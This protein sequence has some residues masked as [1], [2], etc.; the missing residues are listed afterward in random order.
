MSASSNDSHFY[1][2]SHFLDVFHPS[3]W[4]DEFPPLPPL[5][6]N[7][8]QVLAFAPRFGIYAMR[9]EVKVHKL[10]LVNIFDTGSPVNAISSRL[11]KKIKMV[12]N[13]NHAVF[14]GTAGMAS[15]KSIMTYSASLVV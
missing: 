8:P 12:P 4:P 14:Y 15:T 13:L 6:A 11:D 2:E 5:T 10:K 1:V 3:P 7:L 9:I